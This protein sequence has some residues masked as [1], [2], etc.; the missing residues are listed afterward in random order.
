VTK[1]ELARNLQL[2]I[3][4]EESA[5]PVYTKHISDTFFVSLFSQEEKEAAVNIL[6]M[7]S[8]D[9]EGH[10]ALFKALYSRVQESDK[11]VY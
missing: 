11:D 7:L 3:K 2:C 10:A 6:K 5:I 8:R 4:T 9:S 1:E